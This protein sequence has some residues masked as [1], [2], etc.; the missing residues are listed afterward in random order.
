MLSVP[1]QNTLDTCLQGNMPSAP[2]SLHFG[3]E[4]LKIS[5][6][7]VELKLPINPLLL[8]GRLLR[9]DADLG[10]KKLHVTNVLAAQALARH[11]AQLACCDID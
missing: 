1:G 8:L 7:I 4:L 2:S 9:P 6:R 10:A 3:I 11:A 5:P